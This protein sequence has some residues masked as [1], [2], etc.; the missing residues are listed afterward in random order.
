MAHERTVAGI[1]CS[2]VLVQLSAYLDGELE[3][4]AKEQIDAHL[5]GCDTCERFGGQFGD[6]IGTLRR[7]LGAAPPLDR[8]RRD[9]VWER[10]KLDLEEK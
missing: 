3:A 6:A 1:S 4:A 10:V 7:S 8:E 9:R 5:R 2:G